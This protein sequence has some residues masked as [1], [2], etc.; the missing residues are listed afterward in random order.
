MAYSKLIDTYATTIDN[1]FSE[2]SARYNF[3]L[4]EEFEIAI[5]ELLSIVLP[6]KYGVCRGFAVTENDDFA[7]DD[8]LIYDKSRFPTLRL[9][10]KNKFDKKQEIPIE[11]VYGYIEA[12]HTLHLSDERSPQGLH[13]AFSQ[14]INVKQLHREKRE[15]LS[16]DPYSSFGDNF[17]SNTPNWPDSR[18]PMFGAVISRFVKVNSTSL[19]VNS[20]EMLKLLQS[21]P[22][23]TGTIAPDLVILGKSDLMYPVIKNNGQTVYESPFFI[24]GKSIL[25]HKT[26]QK[27]A[28]A[29]GIIML[30]YALDII[31]LDKMPYRKILADYI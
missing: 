4:G 24:S 3:D 29:I 14:V 1:K 8:I 18:N 7:G 2:I 26:V 17:H 21:A 27:S 25:M 22:K 30:L 6:D 20:T 15:V 19:E 31:K 5:C 13:K 9:I 16:I 11:A 28:M 10:V 23:P 12:K